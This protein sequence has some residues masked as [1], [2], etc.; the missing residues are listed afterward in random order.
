MY[1]ALLVKLV[2][3]NYTVPDNVRSVLMVVRIIVHAVAS[4]QTGNMSIDAADPCFVAF[5]VL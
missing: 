5:V 1:P 3:S 2:H 4:R